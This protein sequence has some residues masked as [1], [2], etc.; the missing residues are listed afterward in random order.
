MAAK[1]SV[2]PTSTG[3]RPILSAM[4]LKTSE[5]IRTPKLAAANTGPSRG[6]GIFQSASTAG[7]T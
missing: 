7:A 3:R 2:A 5:P 1:K 6:P 4:V